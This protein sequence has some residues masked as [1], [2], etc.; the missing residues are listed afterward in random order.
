MEALPSLP[1]AA[2]LPPMP[3]HVAHAHGQV[4]GLCGI[5]RAQLGDCVWRCVCGVCVGVVL[6][7]DQDVCFSAPQL[8][9]LGWLDLAPWMEVAV[10]PLDPQ[11]RLENRWAWV[12]THWVKAHSVEIPW[13]HGTR[14]GGWRIVGCGLACFMSTLHR[15]YN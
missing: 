11:W 12:N 13:T 6:Q 15:R 10:D 7:G 4:L 1:F 14:S 3:E 2:P 9:L 5:A 8:W